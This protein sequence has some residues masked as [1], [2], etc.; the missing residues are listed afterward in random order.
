MGAFRVV[1]CLLD[2]A[3]SAYYSPT[4]GAVFFPL[5]C[6][7]FALSWCAPCVFLRASNGIRLA[8]DESVGWFGALSALLWAPRRAHGPLSPQPSPEPREPLSRP[9]RMSDSKLKLP[10][11]EERYSIGTLATARNYFMLP[12]LVG[13]GFSLGMAIG[14]ELF[15]AAKSTVRDWQSGAGGSAQ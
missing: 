3:G 8:S 5:F 4:Q 10:R 9:V 13:V 12:L 11:E 2:Y 6:F 1:H 15:D 14:Y 7:S